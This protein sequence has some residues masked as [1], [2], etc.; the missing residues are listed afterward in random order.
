MVVDVIIPAYNPGGYLSEALAS[1]CAQTHTD[2]RAWVVDDGSS[3]NLAWVD[4]V[5]GR[6]VRIRQA[7]AGLSAARNRG[8]GAGNA[9]LVAFLDA[10]DRWAPDKLAA[11]VE[12]LA[13]APSLGLV[14]TAFRIVDAAGRGERDGFRGFASSHEQLLQGNGICA[15]TVMVRR[16]VLERVGLFAL[17]LRYAQD[18]DLWLRVSAVSE[19]SKLAE[20]LA[21]YRI[22][23]NAMSSD[24]WTFVRE[25]RT[26]LRRNGA[27]GRSYRLARRRVAHNGGAQAFDAFRAGHRPAHLASA[28]RLAPWY[29]TRAVMAKLRP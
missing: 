23:D 1:V 15:S 29:T 18:W 27:R 24:Y 12:A 25:S 7:N 10:D 19:I 11:Q 21:T 6:I 28:L 5:D 8:I 2:W 4:T 13:E 20:P 16:E 17:D 3:E 9:P 14:S 26:V 22:H